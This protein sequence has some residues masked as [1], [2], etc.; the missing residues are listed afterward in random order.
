MTSRQA[1]Q[2]GRR[3]Y[4][5][6]SSKRAMTAVML[7]LAAAIVLL[8]LIAT[9]AAAQATAPTY[10]VL[11]TFTGGT[12]GAIPAANVIADAVGD[13]YGTTVFGGNTSSSCPLGSL[14]CG[15]VFKLDPA[16]NETVLY[17]FTGTT[18][19]SAAE[20]GL[21]RDPAG[22]LYGTTSEGGNTSCYPYG[23][24]V[25]FKL[26]A[27][28]QH[29]KVLYSFSGAD[30]AAPYAGLVRDTAG[31]LYGT[32]DV[33]GDLS[34]SCSPTGCGLVF[35]LDPAGN[36]TVLY[37][38]T[39]GSDGAYPEAGLIRDA[40]GD[41]FGTTAAGGAYGAGVVFKLDPAG[42]ERVLY[43]FTGGADGQNPALGGVVRDPAG[44]LYGTTYFG[45]DTSG[46]GGVGC[47]VV[48]KLDPAGNES[49][50]HTFAGGSDGGN[51]FAGVVR[52]AAGNLYGTTLYGGNT[53]SSCPRGLQGCG[54]VFKVSPTGKETVL[55]TFSG[56]ADGA[57]PQAGLLLYK[58]SLYGT[59]EAGGNTSSSCSSGC[60]VVFKLH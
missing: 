30:G 50:L 52:D 33:G 38:F 32:T 49:V 27:T 5:I 20:G 36:E 13:L 41:L 28:G 12:D 51:P 29:H 53:S 4:G 7:V 60:G 56:G 6:R 58:G 24:G 16:G 25:V 31:N 57:F 46:C 44:N 17:S 14:G 10:T 42:T 21:L 35:K 23:C 2:D 1:N 43:A 55:Y 22:N 54:V 39:G 34:G 48:F 9:T 8:P 3:G 11:Y 26:D 37:R 45:G 19:G 59:T 18:D 15:V 40:T 47:G